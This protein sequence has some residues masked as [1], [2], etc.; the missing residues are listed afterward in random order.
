MSDDDPEAF[1][2][3]FAAR[4]GLASDAP[5]EAF[6]RVLAERLGIS[7]WDQDWAFRWLL[8]R[9][10]APERDEIRVVQQDP[11]PRSAR[12]LGRPARPRPRPKGRP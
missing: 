4:L 11:L 2:R 6:E 5:P 7:R 8:G 1:M 9:R 12:S 10:S 3:R